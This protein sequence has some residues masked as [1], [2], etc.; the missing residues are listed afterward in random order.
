MAQPPVTGKIT[1]HFPARD[2]GQPRY[3][4][5][6]AAR[7]GSSGLKS[8]KPVQRKIRPYI[9]PVKDKTQYIVAHLL[10]EF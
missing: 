5:D 3:L 4:G 10:K 2:D 6:L 9:V 7:T 8:K 1:G